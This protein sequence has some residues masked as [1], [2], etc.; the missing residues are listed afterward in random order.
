MV[1]RVNESTFALIHSSCVNVSTS[2]LV[3]SS[4]VKRTSGTNLAM[5]QIES[6]VHQEANNTDFM[7]Q[8]NEVMGPAVD[9]A[10]DI[11]EGCTGWS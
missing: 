6:A 1:S 10:S 11:C 5:R 4:R 8:Y 2:S 3:H 7:T 9:G